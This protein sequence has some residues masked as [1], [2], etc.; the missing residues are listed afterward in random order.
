MSG[1]RTA[2]DLLAARLRDMAHAADRGDLAL[3]PFMTPQDCAEA[4]RYLAVTGN[5]ERAVF[6]GGYEGAER[7]RLCL[8]PDYL[9]D[10]VSVA[11]SHIAPFREIPDERAQT[12]VVAVKIVGS[13][14]RMLTHRDYLGSLLGLGLERDVLGDLAVQDERSAVVFC[15]E[16]VAQFLLDHLE[17]VANDKVR[18]ASYA[19]DEQFSDGRRTAPVYATVASE[20]LDC[21]VAALTGKSREEARKLVSDGLVEVDYTPQD[22]P[23]RSLALPQTLSIRGIGKFRLLAFDGETKKGR[24]RLRA[25]KFV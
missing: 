18:C 1:E 25:E 16:R 19:V 3:S 9:A 4:E 7:K 15:T 22:R 14:Y 11:V 23:D 13:G 8:L 24:L 2:A 12:A 17:R 10:Y 20:R 6:W 5:A 21:A